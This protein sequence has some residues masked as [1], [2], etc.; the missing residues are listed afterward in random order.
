M[1]V[2]FI[3]NASALGGAERVLLETISLLKQRGVQCRVIAGGQGELVQ[4][5]TAAD[6]PCAVHR[7]GSWVGWEK[8]SVWKQVKTV[9]KVALSVLFAARQVRRWKCDVVYSNGLTVCHGALVAKL[10]NVPH[11][12]HLHE[13]GKEDH[14]LLYECGERLTNRTIGHLSHAC[15]AVSN[16]LSAKYS[17]YIHPS[18][19]TVIYPSMQMARP[20][21]NETYDAVVPARLEQRPLRLLVIGGIVEGKGQADAVQALAYLVKEGIN[22][23][24]ALVGP[25]YSGY[26]YVLEEIIRSEGLQERVDFVGPV[27][28]ASSL[29]K[30]ADVLLV[31]SRSEAFG[32]ATIEG[33][34]VAR[35]VIGARCGATAELIQDGVTGLLYQCRNPLD[36]AAKIRFL[37]EQPDASEQIATNGHDWAAERF[38]GERYADAVLGVLESVSR[39]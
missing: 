36:L 32:R 14:G 24:L 6:V 13:F 39:P 4:A 29:V 1:T 17:R 25:I 16:A 3:S 19:L 22:A 33:M 21:A 12:W 18:K 11:V 7:V 9:V 23:E 20:D 37:Y 34:L 26:R 35:P 28:D 27:K 15:I 5:L 2:C 31:C 10:L 30:D 8:Q 38:S